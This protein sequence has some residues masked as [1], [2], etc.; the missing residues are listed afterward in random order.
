MHSRAEFTASAVWASWTSGNRI[1]EL[2]AEARPRDAAEGVAAQ[3]ALGALAGPAYGWKLAA[4]STAG[5]AHIGVDGPLTGPLFSRFRHEPGDVLPSADMH[6]RVA[7]AEFA[8]V[9]GADVGPDATP[10]ELLAAVASMHLA[11]EIPDSRFTRFE[12]A[13]GPQLI[14]D[15]A[16]AGRFV[17]GPEV[18]GWRE[19][20]LSTWATSLWINGVEAARGSGAAVLGHP[21]A[22][23]AWA[24]EDLR[25]HGRALR[26]GEV[27]TTGTTTP[28]PRIGPGDTVRADFGELG[29]VGLT[30]A[31]R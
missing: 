27:V 6:M 11:I 8:F 3:I 5:Q 2:P 31:D 17:L 22:A 24:A 21:H 25:R 9:M 10:A 28:P 13:G 26:A 29:E 7:E 19:I 12:T 1:P 23:L 18:P 20:E 4:T 16:C 30:I 14:A 15:C